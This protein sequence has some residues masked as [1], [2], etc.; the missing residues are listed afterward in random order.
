[1]PDYINPNP[2]IV[3]LAG[4]DGTITKVK[5]HARIILPEYYD[6]YVKRGFIKRMKSENSPQSANPIHKN[7]GVRAELKKTNKPRPTD[8]KAKIE[9]PQQQVSNIEFK[10]RRQR[11]ARAKKIALNKNIK[12]SSKGLRSNSQV[13]GRKIG[14]NAEELLQSNL[15]E[16]YFPISNNIGVGIL[17]Y[18]R[19]DSLKRLVD[20][21]SLYTDLKKTTVFISDDASDDK[22][23]QK[24]LNYLS[25][26]GD[27]VVLRN[28]TR[29][30]VAGNSNRLIRCLSRFKYGI[31][32]ND[33]VEVLKHGWDNFYVEAMQRTGMHHFIY[34]QIGVYAAYK[35]KQSVKRGIKINCVDERPHGAVLAFTFDMLKEC[36]YFNENYGLY[37]MEH[38]DWSSKVFEFGLQEPGY[39]DVEGSDQFFILHA[40]RSVTED[41]DVHLR[42]A[43]K[44]FASRN[45]KQRIG[46]SLS[47]RVNE[48]TYVV[49][50][51]DFER[52]KSISTVINNIRAQR[53]PVIH[54][55][56]VEQDTQTRINL[57]DYQPVIYL[58]A[59]RNDNQLFNK[60]Y[61]FNIGVKAALSEKII[62][63][64][65]DMM[66]QGDYA[67]KID[68]ILNTYESCHIGNRVIYTDQDSCDIIN[69]TGQV[70]Q[71]T[72]CERVVGYFEGGSLAC[73]KYAYWKCGGFN[74]DFWG[75]GCEDCDFYKRLSEYTKWLEDRSYDFLHLWHSRVSGWNA[76]HDINK[77]IEAK[78][79]KLTVKERVD[80][81]LKQ[82]K[83]NGY[84]T[85]L[86]D[87]QI[88]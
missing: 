46:P 45:K 82:L 11:I 4:P 35:G 7:F 3:H 39:Y 37:G 69:Q 10:K 9:E 23:I 13:V 1:M 58:N 75:Y 2:F 36:G 74:E 21:I 25:K 70:K 62:L 26:T 31:L 38:V 72:K 81:Q 44:L 24:Y 8:K 27:F 57:D 34:R 40:E 83:V 63:H 76:H 59:A 55:I 49:P 14:V 18:N 43:K 16:K 77:A 56:M 84:A 30:G 86:K 60:S 53:F 6:I 54:I 20:S 61:A 80:R 41:R 48:I 79:K 78:L 15:N 32:L 29:L 68:S 52:T 42:Q 33:D 50:F 5:P 66:T 67:A 88:I 47:S 64:D 17:S 85:I 19:L 65:A 12:L 28:D 51:R 71:D 73:T 87:L 22:Q